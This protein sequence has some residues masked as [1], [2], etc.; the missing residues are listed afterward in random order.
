M[1][2]TSSSSPGNNDTNKYR[3]TFFR[4]HPISVPSSPANYVNG[5]ISPSL[6]A[7]FQSSMYVIIPVLIPFTNSLADHLIHLQF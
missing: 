3:S 7:S 1:T 2:I 5:E 4:D 6:D